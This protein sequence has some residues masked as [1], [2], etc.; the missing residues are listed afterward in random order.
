MCFVIFKPNQ[1]AAL[2]QI[3]LGIVKFLGTQVFQD[4]EVACHL[5][6]GTADVRYG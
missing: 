4:E 1:S 6:M 2:L 3:K 5:V